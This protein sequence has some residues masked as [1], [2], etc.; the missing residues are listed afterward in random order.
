[1]EYTLHMGP[2][3]S[4]F[5]VPTALVDRYIKLAGKEQ[6]QVLLWML[7]HGGEAV[8]PDLL[9]QALGMSLDSALDALDY[10][11]QEG[12]A[13]RPGRRALPRPAGPG[14][15]ARGRACPAAR[16]RR[17]EELPARPP[18]RRLLKPDTQHLAAR[19]GESE[20]IRFLMQEAENTLG[21]T[22]SPAM[23]STLLT[24]C[25]DY[26]LPVEVVVMLL[27][28]A[29]NVGRTGTAYIDSVARDRAASGVFTL[30]AAEQKLRELDEHQQAWAKVQSAAGTPR[31]SP[32]KKEEEA[33]YR[34]VYQWK[35][36]VEMLTAAYERCVDN[37]GKFSAGYINKILE[38]W[39]RSGV[40]NLRELEQLEARKR[41]D[42]GSGKSYDIE[43]L[44]RMSFF[45]LP[46][47]L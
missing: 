30:E 46:E 6:L 31:R 4:V 8:Q 24:I 38:G 42:R 18:K 15:A 35:F 40:R 20:G 23:A 17:R 44:E 2:W 37:T 5:A 1:M 11:V 43:E 10:W 32:S 12:L 26:G 41:E 19:M 36:T 9:A 27:H 16:G 33:A 45:D 21:K 29:K 47:E 14:R 22:L 3:S 7:R 39:H 34:W 25:D 13:C 28:Y